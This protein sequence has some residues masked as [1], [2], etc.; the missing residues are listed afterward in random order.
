MLPED[1]KGQNFLR[2]ITLPDKQR[3][4]DA[5]TLFRPDGKMKLFQGDIFKLLSDYDPW[6]AKIESLTRA[7]HNWLSGLQYLDLTSYLPLDILTKVD[8]MSMAH[9]IEA[10]VPLLDHKVVEFAATIPPEMLLRDGRSKHILKRAVKD[11]LPAS[12][13][14]RPK[15]GFATPLGRWLRG[16]LRDLPRDLLLSERSRRRGILDT[17]G[18]ERLLLDPKRRGVMDLPVWTLLSFEMWCR[19]FLDRPRRPVASGPRPLRRD[20]PPLRVAA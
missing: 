10:R 14:E 9:S 8:R 16:P 1:F 5:C 19:T 6:S 17:A 15:R 18:V 4:L 12:V 13:L 3:Y 2:H 7:G 20:G 11:L